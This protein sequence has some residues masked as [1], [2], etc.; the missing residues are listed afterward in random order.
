MLE[1]LL[2]EFAVIVNKHLVKELEAEGLWNRTML[3]E[4]IKK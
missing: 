1:K 3:N 2:V 4:L